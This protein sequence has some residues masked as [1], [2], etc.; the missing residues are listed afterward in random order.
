MK[1]VW[2][3]DHCSQTN[4]DPD[5]ILKHESVCVFNKI[6]KH[7][8][9]CKFYYEAGYGGVHF[10][11][12]EIKKDAYKGEDDGDCDGWIYKYLDKEREEKLNQIGL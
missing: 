6:T 7:C 12:C 11:G 10:P 8:Y 1:Q 4:N 2:K 9:T 5:K 3:C